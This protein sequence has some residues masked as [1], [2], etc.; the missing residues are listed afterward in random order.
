MPP[1]GGR[2]KG[3]D[4]PQGEQRVS[5]RRLSFDRSTLAGADG[6]DSVDG[7]R[8]HPTP[9]ARRRGPA[10]MTSNDAHQKAHT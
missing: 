2:L 9:A 6:V 5:R 10:P 7:D 1:N 4:H 3:K 8:V